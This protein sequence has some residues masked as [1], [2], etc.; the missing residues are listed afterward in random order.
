[1]RHILPALLTLICLMASGLALWS[2]YTL[3]QLSRENSYIRAVAAGE[4]PAF[5][6]RVGAHAHHARTLDLARRGRADEAE[7]LLPRL[8][9]LPDRLQ[10]GARYAIGNARLRA[11]YT[12]M[13]SGRMEEALPHISLAKAAYRE[14]LKIR[15]GDHDSRLNLALAMRLVRDLPRPLKDASEDQEG[16]PRQLWTDLPGLPRGAP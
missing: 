8:S 4:S 16:A 13:D 10:A 7:A 3:W 15:P 12:L 6:D 14:A 2:G 1:M 5:S 11:G 9:G